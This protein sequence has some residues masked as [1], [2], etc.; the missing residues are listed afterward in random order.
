MDTAN[1]E[2]SSSSEE[3]LGTKL[4]RAD[5]LS[6]PLKR[7]VFEILDALVAQDSRFRAFLAPS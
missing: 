2:R 4:R 1:V 7:E 6:H 3:F 5:A